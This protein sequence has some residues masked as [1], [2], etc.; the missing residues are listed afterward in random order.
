MM[1]KKFKEIFRALL[2]RFKKIS[3]QI[4]T[5]PEYKFKNQNSKIKIKIL[6]FLNF[7]ILY[8]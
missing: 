1:P 8:Y 6:K 5:P 7:S 3:Y 4:K 2:A